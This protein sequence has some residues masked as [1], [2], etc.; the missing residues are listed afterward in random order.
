M[1]ASDD[2]REVWLEQQLEKAGPLTQQQQAELRR[3]LLPPTPL[4]APKSRS[5]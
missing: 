5:A 3:V 2:A 1:T 4:P